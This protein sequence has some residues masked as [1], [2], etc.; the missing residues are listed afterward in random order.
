MSAFTRIDE[1][2]FVVHTCPGC[3]GSSHPA[4]GCA[5]SPTMVFCW[6]CTLDWARWVTAHTNG[7][8]RRKGP[9]FYDHV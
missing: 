1:N 6:S 4:T 3:A 2:G 9:A 8:G 5:Y 7:K